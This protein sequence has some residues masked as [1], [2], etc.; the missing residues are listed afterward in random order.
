MNKFPPK[1][2]VKTWI[3]TATRAEF[4]EAQAIA[5]ENI[6]RIFKTMKVAIKYVES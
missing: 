1:I 2:L 3:F 5:I 6:E 4:T